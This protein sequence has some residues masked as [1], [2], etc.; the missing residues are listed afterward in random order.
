VCEA[1]LEVPFEPL[2]LLYRALPVRRWEREQGLSLPPEAAAA[3]C[4]MPTLAK[5]VSRHN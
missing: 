4:V 2:T 1:L 3:Q 5:I